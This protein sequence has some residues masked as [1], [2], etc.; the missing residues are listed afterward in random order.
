MI[1]RNPIPLPLKDLVPL[2][3]DF[4]HRSYVHGQEHVSRVMIHG[5]LLLRLT[6]QEHLAPLLWAAVY[7]HDLARMHDRICFHHGADAARRFHEFRDLFRTVG[8]LEAD[9]HAVRTAVA[10][11]AVRREIA[12]SHRHASLVRLLKD[13]DG[14]DRVRIRD[15]D[16]R[17]LRYSES[18]SLIAFANRLHDTTTRQAE[19]GASYFPWLWERAQA[20]CLEFPSPKTDSAPQDKR[21]SIFLEPGQSAP[22]PYTAHDGFRG[23]PDL[24][25]VMWT[26]PNPAFDSLFDVFSYALTAGGYCYAREHLGIECADLANERLARYK[27]TSRWEGSFEE[28]RCCQFFEQRRFHHFDR[29]PEGDDL[30]AFRALHEAICAAWDREVQ[31]L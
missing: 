1:L 31:V 30:V 24:P 6:R 23:D 29:E 9:E 7:L 28:L 17:Y 12:G 18:N 15:L 8:L 22:K 14:L 4:R 10:W 2:P 5:F 26:R 20:V 16:P 21:R 27:E 25:G 19:P 11:H 3:Q 13:A